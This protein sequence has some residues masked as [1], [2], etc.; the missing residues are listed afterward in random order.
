MKW[1]SSS[2]RWTLL[3]P[4]ALC[5]SIVALP[6]LAADI[7]GATAVPPTASNDR[8]AAGTDPSAAPS[9]QAYGRVEAI[10]GG[11]DS[12]QAMAIKHMAPQYKLRIEM[13]GRGGEYEVAD[14]LKLLQRDEVIA[15]IPD[16]GPWVLLNVPAGRYTLQ[17]QFGEHR[18]QRDVTVA[19]A[20]TTVHWVLPATIE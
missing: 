20:G 15:E 7:A 3:G 17:G 13:S 11:V 1:N 9:P 6:A 8:P 10:N 16:A 2:S 18:M 5:T 19:A 4:L 14:D 12:D